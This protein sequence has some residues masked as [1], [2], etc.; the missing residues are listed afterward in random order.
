MAFTPELR[1]LLQ[2]SPFGEIYPPRANPSQLAFDGRTAALR[3]LRKYICNLTFFRQM[4]A[5]QPNK[6]FSILPKNFFIEWPDSETDA[7]LPSVAVIPARAPYNVIGLVS[8][9][10]E[11]TIDVYGKGTIVQWQS[12]AVEKL[13]LEVRASSRAERRGILA[14]IEVAMSPTEQMSGLRFKMP[15]YFNQ[16]V[17][18]TLNSREVMDDAES[19]KNRRRAQFEIEMRYNVV[20]LVNYVPMQFT[21]DVAVDDDQGE[22]IV[23]SELEETAS[24]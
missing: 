8:Y 13:N 19:A 10:E 12:E 15:E 7:V 14:G 9:V 1:N 17:C 16:L 23:L 11:D 4:G 20:A 24:P 2:G 18:F 22:T 6:A 3:I 5:G 21:A